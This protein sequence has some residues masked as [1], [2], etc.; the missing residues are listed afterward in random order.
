MNTSRLLSALP[1]VLLCA[2]SACEV[3]AGAL[4][5]ELFGASTQ[6]AL[7][8]W[9]I[10]RGTPGYPN[11]L[12][13]RRL[14]TAS[15]RGSA[16]STQAAPEQDAEAVEASLSLDRP[17][18]RLIQRG[19]RNDGFDPGPPDGLFGPRTRSAIRA[20]QA[21]REHAETGFLDRTQADALHTA[22]AGPAPLASDAAITTQTV[23]PDSGATRQ[24]AAMV[25]AVASTRDPLEARDTTAASLSLADANAAPARAASRCD[26]WNTHTF[27]ETATLEEVTAC[28]TLGAD[29]RAR[30]SDAWTPLHWAALYSASPA[31]VKALLAA[32]A[33]GEASSKW[34]YLPLENA[35]RNENP[36][37]LKTMI[38]LLLA[39]GI[40][41]TSWRDARGNTLLHYV[42]V[43]GDS[44]DIE[45]LLAVGLDVSATNENRA[46]PLSIAAQHNRN[47]E[48]VEALLTAGAN[49]AETYRYGETPLHVAAGY[50]EIPGVVEALLAAGSDVTATDRRRDATPLHYAARSNENSAVVEALLAAGADVEARSEE[51]YMGHGYTPLH[52]AAQYN[53]VAVVEA[54]LAAG[55]DVE[56]RTDDYGVTPLHLAPFNNVAVVDVLLAAGADV[57]ATDE[58]ERT[59]LHG[60][61]GN[62]NPA[63]VETLLAAGADVA[64]S[65]EKGE[66]PLHR[67][68]AG[69]GNPAVVETLLTAGADVNARSG[70]GDGSRDGFTPLHA[71]AQS[72]GTLVIRALLAAGADV[73]ARNDHG[74]TPLHWGSFGGRGRI[75]AVETLLAAGANVDTRDRYGWT[76]LHVAAA[77][78][79]SASVVQAL[80][81]AGG[82]VNLK[83]EDGDTPLHVAARPNGIAFDGTQ[84]LAEDA[85]GAL[86]D[87]GADATVRN[88]AGET[89]W[90]LARDNEGL[91]RDRSDAYW[92]LNDARFNAPRQDSRRRPPAT[93]QDRRQA[94]PSTASRSEARTCEISGY[95]TPANFQTLGLNWCSSTVGIQVRAFALQAAGA[96]CAIAEGTS[97]SPEQINAR[98]QEIN[99][100]CDA[101]DALGAR[102]GPPCQC[103][104]GYRP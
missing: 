41:V 10:S 101:L 42:V 36:E 83:T 70:D 87:A 38:E 67:A 104:A 50:N 51:D 30:D 34:G 29:V 74:A 31:V 55:A 69:N 15:L 77:F 6:A 46:T 91:Q 95:P 7:R 4:R 13:G 35:V 33:D 18:R 56:A 61:A 103:P 54:L 62:E 97:S 44:A 96:W 81:A 102:G 80:I 57:T 47:P 98:H 88:A 12:G 20:W 48:A 11:G 100:A 90:D 76:P 16:F 82:D 3:S 60:A 94:P 1:L 93:R 14:M 2:A 25:E 79:N 84:P 21:A 99:A 17:T 75:R 59:P 72:N 63:V 26:A 45:R 92:R 64:A 40:N 85:I 23:T 49:A 24:Q 58:R 68:A 22:G 52:L 66:T 5:H 39:T 53:S 65:D 19:L 27:F 86:L 8:D 28:L 32:G 89:P 71:A 9:Q 37:V 78:I 73:D 43:Y